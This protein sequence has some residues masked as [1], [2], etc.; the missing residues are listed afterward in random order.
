MANVS[1]IV[2]A[3]LVKRLG[4]ATFSAAVN[5]Y[6]VVATDAT[7]VFLGDFVKTTGEQ[8]IW[9]PTGMYYPV[10]TQAA[11]TNTLRGFIVGFDPNRSDLSLNYRLASTL[12]LVYVCDDPYALFILERSGTAVSTDVG[13]NAD[14]TVG[15]GNTITG[16]SGMQIDGT[17]IGTGSAQIRILALDPAPNNELGAYAKYICMINEHELKGTTG[18]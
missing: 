5:P 12:R 15:A 9:A 18:V 7:A 17:T 4:T 10:I 13:K 11:A 2:G 8:A 14:I 3:E 1:R 6:L 16:T